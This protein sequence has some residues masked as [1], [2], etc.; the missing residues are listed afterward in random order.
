M[1]T[2]DADAAAAWLAAQA[3]E[4]DADPLADRRQPVISGNLGLQAEDVG[5]RLAGWQV[6]V[7]GLGYEPPVRWRERPYGWKNAVGRGKAATFTWEREGTPE[8]WVAIPREQGPGLVQVWRARLARADPAVAVLWSWRPGE[9][10]ATIVPVGLFELDAEAAQRAIRDVQSLLR[11]MPKAGRPRGTGK[12]EQ[13]TAEDV[14]GAYAGCLE[15]DIDFPTKA[16]VVDRLGWLKERTLER[17][18]GDHGRLW[19]PSRW[20]EWPDWRPD[21]PAP[22]TE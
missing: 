22:A 1:T 17:W 21:R 15:D 4:V 12:R 9:S 6:L 11:S 18:M 19:P 14:L 2:L 8:W 10:A 5:D 7:A 3:A 13:L 20:P 16:D